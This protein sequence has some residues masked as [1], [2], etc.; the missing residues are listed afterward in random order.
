M[1]KSCQKVGIGGLAGRVVYQMVVNR[2]GRL[3]RHRQRM[4]MHMDKKPLKSKA[5]LEFAERQHPD[6]EFIYINPQHCPIGQYL[7]SL[8]Y[9]DYGV[10]GYDYRIGSERIE[11]PKRLDKALSRLIRTERKRRTWGNLVSE[12]RKE[13]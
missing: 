6:K 13:W 4:R 8:G 12:L 1:V 3:K 7:Q 9:T 2:S 11:I 5:F 10:G